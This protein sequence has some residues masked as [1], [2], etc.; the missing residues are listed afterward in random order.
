MMKPSETFA[1]FHTRFLY[2]AGQARIP[3]DDLQLDLFDKLTIEL[4]RTILLVYSTLTTVKTL[5]DECLSLDQGFRKLKACSER[6]KSCNSTSTTLP[7]KN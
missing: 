5:V 7:M 4:Q 1:D 3:K 6:L 2:L